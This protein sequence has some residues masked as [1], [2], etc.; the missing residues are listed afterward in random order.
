MSVYLIV[1]I[2]TP[3]SNVGI[4]SIFD[5]I[6]KGW[7]L[8][9]SFSEIVNKTKN[10]VRCLST[11]YPYL[12]GNTLINN[13]PKCIRPPSNAKSPV[14]LLKSICCI[15]I[16]VCVFVCVFVCVCVCVCVCLC[17]CVSVCL[18]ECASVYKSEHL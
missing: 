18:P 16:C 8:E 7:N 5:R 17:I 9:F 6:S 10:R 1:H 3:L 13:L 15:Y 12:Y 4:M 2:L 11:I 14:Q